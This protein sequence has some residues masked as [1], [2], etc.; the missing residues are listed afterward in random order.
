M[1]TYIRIGDNN[2]TVIAM[3]SFYIFIL[4]SR[5]SAPRLLLSV[6]QLNLV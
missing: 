2:T 4:L 5:Q 3:F 1:T 6:A